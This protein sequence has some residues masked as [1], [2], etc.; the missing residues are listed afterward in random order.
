MKLACPE[1]LTR[2]ASPPG[3]PHGGRNEISTG[4]EGVDLK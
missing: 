3:W 4:D 1:N 2:D